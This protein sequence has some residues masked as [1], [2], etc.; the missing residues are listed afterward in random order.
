VEAAPLDEPHVG[1]L[2]FSGPTSASPTAVYWNPAALGLVRGFQV[3]VVGAGRHSRIGVD[4]AP[5]D[6][7][8]G[9]PGSF[10]PG[11][12]TSRDL[13]QP[14]QWPPGPGGYLGISSDLGG[15]RFTLAFATYTPFFEQNRY[16]AQ[17]DGAEPTRYHRLETDLRNL[18]LVPALAVRFGGDF[19]VGVAPGFLFSTGRMVFAEGANVCGGVLCSPED[20]G[21]AARYDV[22]S[23]QSILDSTFSVTLGGGL[24]YRRRSLE[25]GL[26]YSSRPL[27]G[28]TE[29]VEVNGERTRVTLP[30]NSGGGPLTCANGQSNRCVFGN[31]SYKLPDVWIGGVTWRPRA[32]LEVTGMVRWLWFSV[33]DRVD[34]RLTGLPLEAAGL[35][36]HV[37]LHRG[38]KDVWDTRVRV[39]Y[40]LNQHLRVGGTVR[41][42]TSAVAARDVSPAAVDGLKLQPIALAELQVLRWL[43]IG[44]G[45]GFTLMS[46]VQASPSAF[47]PTAA[48]TCAGLGGDLDDASCVARSQGRAR[49]TAEGTYSRFVHDFSLSTTFRF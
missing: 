2:S 36:E 31:I 37:V 25:F 5:I 13:S 47:D 18:A 45:Y 16:P 19:R 30:P 6:P 12:A 17:A 21:A 7:A 46:S 9:L 23:G 35:T 34:V 4:R 24:Y 20:P 27:G 14:L 40:W 28:D 22:S 39:S 32:G 44:A 49:P 29:G 15:D 43:W 42:E 33:H 26:A 38:F 3:M 1:G 48:A 10:D 41:V 11:S 8:S